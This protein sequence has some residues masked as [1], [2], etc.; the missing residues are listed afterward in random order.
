MFKESHFI[1]VLIPLAILFILAYAAG[2]IAEKK[3]R[4]W[5]G[6][7]FLALFLPIIGLIAAAIASPAISP[8]ASSEPQNNITKLEHLAKLKESGALSEEEFQKEKGKII[9]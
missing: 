3:G 5:Y 4:S 2:N 1:E 8:I 6:F 9:T 7:F